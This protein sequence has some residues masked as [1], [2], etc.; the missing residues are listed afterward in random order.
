MHTKYDL[1]MAADTKYNFGNRMGNHACIFGY[2]GGN[3]IVMLQC[4]FIVQTNSGTYCAKSTTRGN[5]T[6]HR[7]VYYCYILLVLG[8][9]VHF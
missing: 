8:V 7:C 1:V 9:L 2:G 3:S 6:V 5:T 4:I